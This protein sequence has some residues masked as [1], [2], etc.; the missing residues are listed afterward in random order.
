MGR[1]GQNSVISFRPLV[2]GNEDSGNKIE[3]RAVKKAKGLGSRM[4]P[5]VFSKSGVEHV[6]QSNA[7][8][9]SFLCII[10]QAM[11]AAM[12]KRKVYRY[13]SVTFFF[14]ISLLRKQVSPCLLR[15][16]LAYIFSGLLINMQYV[17]S[18]RGQNLSSH[19]NFLSTAG[20]YR[21]RKPSNNTSAF[22]Q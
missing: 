11:Q 16:S 5:R 6:A 7:Q 22:H 19:R 21:V 20:K 3:E 8:L 12:V 18:V 10:M 14:G 9:S 13:A 4:D 2:K 17:K 15:G 1:D